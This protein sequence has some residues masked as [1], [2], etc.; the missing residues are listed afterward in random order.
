MVSTH[1]GTADAETAQP[2]GHSSPPSTLAQVIASIRESRDEQTELL[3]LLMT[4]YNCEGTTVGNARDQ[5]RSSYVEFLA[6]QPPTFAKASEPLEADHWLRT[7]ESKF[8]LLNCTEIQKTLFAAQQLLGGARAWWASFTATRPA[9]QVQW[10]EFHEAFH[11]QHIPSGIMKSKCQEF[12]D[13]QQGNQSVYTYS[14]MF[15]HLTQYAPKKVDTDEKKYRLMN[16]LSTKM[17]ERLAL[18]TNWTFRELVSNAIIAD[19]AIRAHQESKKKKALTTPSRSAPP[20]YRMVCTPHYHPPQQQHQLVTYPPHHQD[21]VPRAMA[22]PLTVSHRPSQKLG[23]VPCTCYRYG[24]V[25]HF[26]KECTAPRQIDAPPAE[27]FLP[28]SN[29]C[30]YQNRPSKLHHYGCYSRGRTSP[31]GYLFSKWTPHHHPI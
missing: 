23:V 3:H 5:A 14:M 8:E 26:I 1:D 16:G 7:L 25:G 11:A 21:V 28:S 6:T 9:N 4:N 17:Q 15:N 10:A 18:N 19:D 2:G 24:H 22:P 20:K 30:C 27:S 31:R 13:L 29:S 12:M